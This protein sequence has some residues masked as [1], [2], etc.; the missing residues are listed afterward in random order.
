MFARRDSGSPPQEFL[1]TK[2]QQRSI[3]TL[4]E[5][6]LNLKGQIDSLLPEGPVIIF[7]LYHYVT[8]KKMINLIGSLLVL[9]L[10]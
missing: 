10:V 7:L 6:I 4:A 8:Q 5:A 1:L 2:A 9:P 3:G